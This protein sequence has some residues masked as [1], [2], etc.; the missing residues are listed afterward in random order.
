[1]AV[2][3]PISIQ[4]LPL[5][6]ASPADQPHHR[7]D[8]EQDDGDEE[9]RLGDFDGDAG[10]AAKTQNTRDQRD[11]QKRNYPAQHDTTSI[12]CC[13]RDDG[14]FSVPHRLTEQSSAKTKVPERET[15]KFH[16][17]GGTKSRVCPEIQP[18]KSAG[19]KPVET[20]GQ[21]LYGP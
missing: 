17:S 10:D 13:S 8:Q 18:A 7:R 16:D 9:D 14:D 20:A 4:R 6:V 19:I 15:P 3:A 1:M 12:G 21:A 2:T 11:D 5:N